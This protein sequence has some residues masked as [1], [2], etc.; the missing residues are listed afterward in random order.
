MFSFIIRKPGTDNIDLVF[1]NFSKL[2]IEN[3]INYQLI[4]DKILSTYIYFF[5]DK[6]ICL[7]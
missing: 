5:N 2:K 4:R 7:F 3:F 1:L 6:Y